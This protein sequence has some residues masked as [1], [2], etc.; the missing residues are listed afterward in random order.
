MNILVLGGT[1]ML[2]HKMFQQL[3]M[4]YPETYCTIRGSI[5]DAPVRDVDLFHSGHVLE[6]CGF[7]DFTVVERLLL[8]YKSRVVVNCV[9]IVKQRTDSKK[10]VPSIYINSLLP[11]LLLETCERMGAKLIHV[12]TDCVFSGKKGNYREDDLPDAEDLYGRTKFLG[13]V[14]SGSALTLRTSIIGRELLHSESLLEWFLS[15]NHKR[16]SGYKRALFSGVTTNHL[17]KVVGD[18]ISNHPNLSGLYNVA[19]QTISKF[20]L[21]CLLRE[22]YDLDIEILPKDEF[23]CD[24]S[25]RGEK[26][27]AATGYTCAPWPELVSQLASDDTP[28]NEWRAVKNEVL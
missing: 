13:E 27:D 21:L 3:R 22:A 24:R 19:S 28:Y 5:N 8:E 16:V 14:T 4:R 1:G 6:Q 26:F 23:S 9:G 7:A 15:Q 25:L 12:S 2:G 11:H 10:P 20:D 18:L 17:A